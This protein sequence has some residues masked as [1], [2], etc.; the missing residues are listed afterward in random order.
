MDEHP[1]SAVGIIPRRSLKAAD[2]VA[3]LEKIIAEPGTAPTYA[4][5]DNGPEISAY[6]LI[7]CCDPTGVDTASSTRDHVAERLHLILQRPFTREQLSG[8]SMDTMAE[9]KYWADGWKQ[10]TSMNGPTVP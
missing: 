2:V 10:S 1:R 9:A 3:A 8:E 4:R 6:A 5:C 7:D